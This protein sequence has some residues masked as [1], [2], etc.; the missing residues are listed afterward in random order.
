[1]P[2]HLS[3]Q[4]KILPICLLNYVKMW[5]YS[6][7]SL[8]Y[9]SLNYV[10]ILPFKSLTFQPSWID[11]WLLLEKLKIIFFTCSLVF[12]VKK[13]KARLLLNFDVEYILYILVYFAFA[14]FYS[15]FSVSEEISLHFTSK[16]VLISELVKEI[17]LFG[18]WGKY[19]IVHANVIIYCNI[20][21][22]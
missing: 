20:K 3:F 8:S 9:I 5:F 19:T 22:M 10:F 7:H 14:L 16:F 17:C 21:I 1:M 2:Y 13:K 6:S 4:I 12:F 11:S 15:V 18:L